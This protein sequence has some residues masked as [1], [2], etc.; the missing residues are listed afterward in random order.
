MDPVKVSLFDQVAT[1]GLNNPP[2][3]AMSLGL[4]RAL[5]AALSELDANPDVKAIGIYGIGKGFSAGADITEFDA[6]QEPPLPPDVTSAIAGTETPTVA[7]LH[8]PTLGGGF[9]MG[10]AAGTRV[11]LSGAKLGTPEV[12]IG[13]IPGAGGCVRSAHLVGIEAAIDLVTTGRQIGPEEA[14][15][16]GFIDRIDD[17]DPAEVAQ[18]AA[19]DV[20]AGAL[21]ARR[22]PETPLPPAP[23]VIEAA[24]EALKARAP[25]LYAPF[26]ALDAVAGATLPPEDALANEARLFMDCLRNPQSAALIHAFGAE[27]AVWK[28]PEAGSAPRDVGAVGV[29]GGGTMGSGI[30]TAALLS[31][32]RVTLVEQTA[33]GQARAKATIVRNLGGALKRGKITEAQMRELSDETLTLSGTL[34]SLND[35]DLIIEAVFED[36]AVKSAIFA[37]LDTIAKPGAVLASNTSALNLNDI[38]AATN[39]PQDVIGLHF[40]SPAHVMKLLEVAVGDKTAADT[41]STGFALARRLRKIPVRSGVCDGF[42]G[43]RILFRYLTVADDLVLQGAAPHAVDQAMEALGFALG[44]FA[45]NDMAG[46][47]ISLATRAPKDGLE[48]RMAAQG[49][50]GRKSG[51]GYYVYEGRSSTP[52]PDVLDML[53]TLRA[54]RQMTGRTFSGSE[55]S[56]HILTAMIAEAMDVLEEGIALR[57][58]DIDAVFLFGYGFP[59][60][61]GGPMHYADHIGAAELVD[62]IETYQTENAAFWRVPPLLRKHAM[63]GEKIAKLNR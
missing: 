43:N 37:E 8:G 29:V 12:H 21:P 33:E 53:D 18:G 55:I 62:R 32:L 13:L 19:R 40:F 59:R 36:M 45:V 9:E 20:L 52:N 46:L 31:G 30:A 41:T 11:A 34:T 16:I 47:D 38:A 14:L 22:P 42:I 4:R 15:R 2:V 3:N 44:P 61:L 5:V 60:Q 24:R 17:G 56:D 25:L 48:A 63:S 51:K 49:W 57:P 35:A 6:A 1:I 28:I 54:E 26:K 23:D 58:V 7:I 50:L 27:R 39:R 10:L